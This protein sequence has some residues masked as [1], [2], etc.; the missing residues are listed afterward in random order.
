[1]KQKAKK[2]IKKKPTKKKKI[3]AK[4]IATAVGFGFKVYK[5]IK[6]RG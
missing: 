6:R 4:Q 5:A 2:P 3:S 1:M